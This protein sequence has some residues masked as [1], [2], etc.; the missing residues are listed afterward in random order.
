MTGDDRRS[1]S[2]P[3]PAPPRRCRRRARPPAA[4]PAGG[5]TGARRD[6][7]EAPRHR[8]H[9][10]RHGEIGLGAPGRPE[11]SP[12]KV[13]PR[14]FDAASPQRI[15]TRKSVLDTVD[16]DLSSLAGAVGADDRHKLDAHLT[17][18]RS[19]EARLALPQAACA[20]SPPDPRA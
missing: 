1:P 3:T 19:I 15:A 14:L 10:E 2:W 12:A 8:V 16:V 5:S 4:V 6:L 20:A 18:V 17:A 11:V 7:P 13:L 9:A